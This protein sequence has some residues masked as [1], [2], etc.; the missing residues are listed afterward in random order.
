M[1]NFDA[2]LNGNLYLINKFPLVA[3]ILDVKYF[4]S[5]EFSYT[6]ILCADKSGN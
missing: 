2:L 3:Q 6:V 1:L 4:D 5:F